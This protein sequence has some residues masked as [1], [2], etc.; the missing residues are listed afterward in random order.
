MTLTGHYAKVD[1][2]KNFMIKKYPY[3]MYE[4][5]LACLYSFSLLNEQNIFLLLLEQIRK[6]FPKDGVTEE[7]YCRMVAEQDPLYQN[8]KLGLL[9][10]VFNTID[11]DNS[12]KNFLLFSHIFSSVRFL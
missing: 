2:E 4:L 12:G 1:D 8:S 5:S 6:T 9:K 7:Q 3:S 10:T 11:R